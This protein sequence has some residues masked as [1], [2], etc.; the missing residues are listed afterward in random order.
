MLRILSHHNLPQVLKSKHQLSVEE[1]KFD[2]WS[3]GFLVL[4][5][6]NGGEVPFNGNDLSQICVDRR[7]VDVGGQVPRGV[8]REL[9]NL[10][11]GLIK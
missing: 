5:C 9:V 6:L 2:L 3:L 8:C 7:E 4:F 11:Q 10:V 1:S